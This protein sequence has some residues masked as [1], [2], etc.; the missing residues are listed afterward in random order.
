MRSQDFACYLEHVPG[1]LFRL[2]T[3]V[4]RTTAPGLHTPHFDIDERALGLVV[5]LFTHSVVAWSQPDTA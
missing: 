3:V 4:A 1:V 2:G 5:K